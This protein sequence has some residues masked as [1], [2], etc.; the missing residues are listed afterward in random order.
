MDQRISRL[1]GVGTF[2]VAAVL[3]GSAASLAA[4]PLGRNFDQGIHVSGVLQALR[5]ETGPMSGVAA[6]Q[7]APVLLSWTR[8]CENITFTSTDPL[9]SER[10]TLQSRPYRVVCTAPPQPR[11][12]AC[13]VLFEGPSDVPY[14]LKFSGADPCRIKNAK[15]FASV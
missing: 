2:V 5:A 8:G 11:G 12:K 10:L 3:V 9:L 4:N 1:L 6:T 15:S 13:R 7:A 14:A